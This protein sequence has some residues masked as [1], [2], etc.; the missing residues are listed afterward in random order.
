MKWTVYAYPAGL[1][2]LLF[3]NAAR[4]VPGPDI[5]GFHDVDKLLHILFFGLLAI[6]LVR[7]PGFAGKEG[8]IA[9]WLL[10]FLIGSADE[11]LQMLSLYRTTDLLD[12]A[13]DAFG[14]ALAISLYRR[15]SAFRNLLETGLFPRRASPTSLHQP[16][17]SRS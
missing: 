15:W 6:T 3:L 1:S 11:L 5:G 8:P 12:L 14:A 16:S 7:T 2:A 9:A 17:P 10:T 4:P 13:A